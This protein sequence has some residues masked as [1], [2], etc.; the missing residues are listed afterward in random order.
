LDANGNLKD[1][2]KKAADFVE[3]T[4]A[5]TVAGVKTFSSIPVLPASNPTTDNQAA[6]KAYVDALAAN[7]VRLTTAQTVAGVKTFSNIPVLPESDPT[8]GNQAARKAYVDSKI[9][10]SLGDSGKKYAT[11]VI[12][13]TGAGHTQND[14]DY[15]CN[16]TN[17]QTVINNAITALRNVGGKIIIREGTYNLGGPI[18]M[19]QFYVTL[20]GMGVYNTKLHVVSGFP[21]D[22]AVIYVQKTYCRIADLDFSRDES[23]GFI[24]GIKIESDNTIVERNHII[25]NGSP[26]SYGIYIGS[27][28]NLITGNIVAG[29]G[30]SGGVSYGIYIGGSNNNILNNKVGGV[31]QNKGIGIFV[32]GLSGNIV[33]QNY[34][35]IEKLYQDVTNTFALGWA[36]GSY[37]LIFNNNLTGVTRA[38]KPGSAYTTDSSS[39]ATLPGSVTTVAALGTGGACGFNIV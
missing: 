17:D 21:T 32:G 20:Q 2:G 19:N 5:Q 1:S 37:N 4:G 24:Y 30:G 39:A 25:A 38:T 18:I 34:I 12:G 16:G 33:M 29:C 6:R 8:D 23:C 26:Y 27:G 14:V 9:G 15:L 3:M 22:S 7:F 10:S 28:K 11:F 36:G 31:F 35:N 13:N